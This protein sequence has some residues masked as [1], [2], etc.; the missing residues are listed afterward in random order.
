MFAGGGVVC[1]V[2]VWVDKGVVAF[3]F[4]YRDRAVKNVPGLDVRFVAGAVEGSVVYSCSELCWGV[5]RSLGTQPGP[6][7]G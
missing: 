7:V 3:A 4:G 2:S 6:F 1:V 5:A